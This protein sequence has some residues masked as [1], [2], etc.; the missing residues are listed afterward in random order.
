MRRVL[1]LLRDLLLVLCV[2][3]VI[4]LLFIALPGATHHRTP[5]RTNRRTL[6]GI[7]GNRPNHSTS[8]RATG[9]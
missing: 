1:L 6:A 2:R 8:E 9:C 7:P 4:R 3:L 5:D